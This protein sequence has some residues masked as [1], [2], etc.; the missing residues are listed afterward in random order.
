MAR[1]YTNHGD[2]LFTIDELAVAGDLSISVVRKWISKGELVHFLT[3]YVQVPGNKYY[4]KLGLP[5]EDDE[6]IEGETFK[7]KLKLGGKL[8]ENS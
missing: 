4:Y 6:L 7:Y 5:Y 3:V 8:R 1:L 2:E